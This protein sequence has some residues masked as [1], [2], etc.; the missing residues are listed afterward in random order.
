MIY[1]YPLE[2]T[3][4]TIIDRNA[5]I[6]QI[7]INKKIYHHIDGIENYI[8][9][10]ISAFINSFNREKSKIFNFTHNRYYYTSIYISGQ[11]LR[12]HFNIDKALALI[13]EYPLQRISLNIFSCSNCHEASIKYT[14]Y[15]T[16][17]KYRYDLC[18]IPVIIVQYTLDG[19]RY[20]LIDGNHRV[21]AK[22]QTNQHSVTGIV[23]TFEDSVS[24]IQSE[25]ERALYT[26]LYEGSRV[27][28]F[29][30]RSNYKL[31]L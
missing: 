23:L 14:E 2:P 15:T 8:D 24:L 26:F 6:S 7:N 3:Y 25:F 4:K 13:H 30:N 10:W 9:N 22:K 31:F 12:I 28:E 5:F 16:N 11:E 21:T 27:S 18:E 17:N 20:L 1:R 29:I 19:F